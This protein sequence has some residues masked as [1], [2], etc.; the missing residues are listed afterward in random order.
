MKLTMKKQ[1]LLLLSVVLF[2]T[3]S[4]DAQTYVRYVTQEDLHSKV[5]YADS[6]LTSIQL[7]RGLSQLSN[8]PKFNAAAYELSQVLK[9]PKK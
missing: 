2:S 3:L 1:I 6:V 7:P 8:Y 5:V 9:D 4:L